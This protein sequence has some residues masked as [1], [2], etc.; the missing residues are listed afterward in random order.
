MHRRVARR[1]RRSPRRRRSGGTGTRSAGGRGESDR[2]PRRRPRTSSDCRTAPRAPATAR[3]RRPSRPA[4]GRCH[5]RA[6]EVGRRQIAAAAAC[7]TSALRLDRDLDDLG[8]R[9][10]HG[11]RRARPGR[12]ARRR[13]RAI[14]STIPRPRRAAMSAGANAARR[15]DVDE[16]GARVERGRRGSARVP[17]RCPRKR[18]PSHGGAARHDHRAAPTLDRPRGRPGGRRRRA[19]VRRGR[20]SA[21]RRAPGAAPPSSCRHGHAELAASRMR[22]KTKKPPQP[23]G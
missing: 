5:R 12:R 1:R 18:P 10:P 20:P 17:P 9:R 19:A 6:D 8:A 15:L 22:L 16:L 11:A 3:Q 23:A 4:R 7:R 2:A 21:R 14:D 13:T